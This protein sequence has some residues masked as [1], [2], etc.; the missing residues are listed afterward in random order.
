[1]LTTMSRND[2]ARVQDSI[3]KDPNSRMDGAGSNGT[4]SSFSG[5]KHNSFNSG[6]ATPT[7]RKFGSLTFKE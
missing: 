5:F 6:D 4:P 3:L 7:N 1:M 2:E